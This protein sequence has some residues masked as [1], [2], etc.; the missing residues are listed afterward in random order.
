MNPLALKDNS[1]E[2]SII[3]EKTDSVMEHPQQGDKDVTPKVVKGQVGKVIE[4]NYVL[5]DSSAL[6]KK[7]RNEC[8]KEPFNLGTEAR[9][10]SNM[11]IQ[12][13]TS[14]FEHVK[15]QFIND[16]LKI[17]DIEKVE[18]AIG[19]KQIIQVMLL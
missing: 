4:K 11:V 2:E 17:E 13:K 14:F 15:A 8:R 5:N 16:L 6:K 19:A 18:N 1:V 10:G 9:D 12:M 3:V 7:K